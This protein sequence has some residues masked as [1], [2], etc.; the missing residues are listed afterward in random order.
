MKD[1]FLGKW[2]LVEMES[3]DQDFID[4]VEPGY[5][6]FEKGGAGRMG[7]GA[8][9]LTLDWDLDREGKVEFTFQGFDEMDEVSGRGSAMID[10][11]KL[12]GRIKFH[13]GDQSG[14]T[15]EKWRKKARS[16]CFG[17]RA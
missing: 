13:Q 2:H 6:A 12:I 10:S 4:L 1:R 5:I 11:N 8:V 14:F 3:W 17:K 15:A 9:D 16:C 7:F